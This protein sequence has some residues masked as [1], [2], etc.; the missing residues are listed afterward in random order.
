MGIKHIVKDGRFALAP[1]LCVIKRHGKTPTGGRCTRNK[2]ELDI[3]PMKRSRIIEAQGR[4]A[5]NIALVSPCLGWR[6]EALNGRDILSNSR[7]QLNGTD[8]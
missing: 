3:A 4:M 2:E 5:I 6:E 8:G 1:W 7:G